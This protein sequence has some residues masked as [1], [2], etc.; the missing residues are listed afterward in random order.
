MI[1]NKAKLGKFYQRL[2]QKEN[3]SYKQALLIYEALHNEAVSL[4]VISSKNIL[5][6]LE[7]D[8]KIA[9]TINK[10]SASASRPRIMPKV[11]S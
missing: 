3:I 11:I 1:K 4:R 8:I 5:D 7:I 9:K 6:G 2:I 10:L